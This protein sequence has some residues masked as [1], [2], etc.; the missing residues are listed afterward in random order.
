ML[1]QTEGA[2]QRR[3]I[4]LVVYPGFKTLEATG[5]LSVLGYASQHLAAAGRPGGYDVVI[6]APEAGPVPSDTL[7]SLEASVALRDLGASDTVLIAGA[8][9]I[10]DALVRETALVAWC[11]DSG[12]KVPRCAALCTGSFFLAEA[13]L[14]DG[15]RA[16]THWNYADRL[17]QRFPRVEVDADAIFV[18][19]GRFWTSAGVTAAIDLTLAFVEQDYGRDIALAVARDMVMYL[20]RPGGQSQFSTL[21]T[22]Q[23]AGHGAGPSSMKDVL[24]W[25]GERLDQPLTLDGIATAHGMSI[26]SLSRAFAAEI[27]ASPMATLESLRCDTA[28]ALL[29]DTDLPMKTVAFRA[30]FRTDEQMRKAFRRRFSLSPRDYRARFATAGT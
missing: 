1:E 5:P 8:A 9:R 18:Q 2:D 30:G 19:A 13:G 28:K 26:R 23:M 11:R 14:L 22:G 10:E 27:G 29:L 15:K 7:M 25:M 20:K 12:P 3:Q 4:A 16:A 21:L 6:A 24:S 17:R